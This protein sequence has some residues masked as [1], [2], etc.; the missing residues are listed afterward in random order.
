MR[1]VLSIL[2]LI[3]ILSVAACGSPEAEPQVQATLPDPEVNVI[4]QPTSTEP[5]PT[6]TAASV[7]E[8]VANGTEIVQDAGPA[9]A[10]GLESHKAN[11]EDHSALLG[12]PGLTLMRHNG[13]IWYA[14]EPVEGERNWAAISE[15]EGKLE[16]ADSSGLTTILIV[17]GTP[18]W[19]QLVPGSFCGPILPA[20]LQ[21]FADF[22]FETVSR[23]S[24]PPYNV[25]YWELGNEPD[26]DPVL[27]HPRSVFGCW[28]NHL[29]LY[30]GGDYYAEML[31]RVYPA[32]KN[33][34]PEAQVLLGGL[35]LDCDPNQ[36]PVDKDCHAGNFL[37]GVLQN[38]GGDYFDI[39]S[40]HGYTPYFGPE[41]V[42]PYELYMDDHNPSWEHLGGVVDGKI[43]FIRQV[44]SKYQVDKPIFHTEGALMCAEYNL[45]DCEEPGELFFDAQAEYATRRYVRNWAN[46][47]GATIWYQF[48]GPGW[49]YGGMLDEDQNPKPVYEALLFMSSMLSDTT[50]LGEISDFDGLQGY[51]F[52]APDK[53]IWVLWSPEQVDISIQV[54]DRVNNIYDK[55]GNEIALEGN[56]LQVNSAIYLEITN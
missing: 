39:V 36:P 35:L 47:V 12:E 19:A 13:L 4:V 33:A 30:Y 53:Q 24:Q 37:E 25:K 2:G 32:I 34:D 16:R 7:T 10:F 11:F 45:I 48:E 43:N 17:R 15:L 9:M 50:Y 29:G 55:F 1:I 8:T 49:R 14:V 56:D 54:P 23:Y 27:V 44:M 31:K 52:T 46:G 40:F 20:K 18:E 26:V 22:M 41:T 38:G 21:S 3:F 5:L 28:G 42:L 6:E 51:E